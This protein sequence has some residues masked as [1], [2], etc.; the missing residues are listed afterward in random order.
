[1]ETRTVFVRESSII[2][3]V[4]G[5]TDVTLFIFAGAAAEFALSKQADWLY[6]TGSLPADPIGRLFST[7]RYAQ[8]I[9]FSDADIALKSIAR[10]NHIHH[11]IEFSRRENIPADGYRHVLYMLI[12]YSIASF[13]LLERKLGVEEKNE[14]VRVFRD[15]GIQMHIM[16]TPLDYDSWQSDYRSIL[17][18]D[19]ECS[20]FT[21][22]LF[23]QY[24]KHLG[25]LRY[26]LLLE[27]QRMIVPRRVNVLLGLGGNRFGK[28]LITIYK[29]IRKFR[30]NHYIINLLMPRKFRKE[31]KEWPTSGYQGCYESSNIN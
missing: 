19:A 12:H 11:A 7:V 29:L 26:M 10:I 22:D 15:V 4:W 30:M 24:R 5:T 17:V 9:I 25:A 3:Q 8:Q 14:I 1:M 18:S 23:K 27:V 2:R 6:F 20:K 28:T 13:E 31:L 21:K 16:D